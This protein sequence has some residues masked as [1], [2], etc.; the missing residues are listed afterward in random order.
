VRVRVLISMVVIPL[1]PAGCAKT[2]GQVIVVPA[3]ITPMCPNSLTDIHIGSR[4]SQLVPSAP[5][6]AVFCKY[7]GMNEKVN[8]GT[9]VPKELVT[10]W[11]AG[12]GGQDAIGFA[13]SNNTTTVMIPTSGC[14][15]ASSTNTSGVWIVS[16]AANFALQKLDPALSL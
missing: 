15:Y 4:L 8:F 10:S 2:S 3:P 1:M 7:A 12:F 9:L 14:P 11:A 5:D 6:R 13:K 16:K